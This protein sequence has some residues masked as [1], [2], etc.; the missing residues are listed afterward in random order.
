VYT[1]EAG[2]LASVTVIVLVVASTVP[3][4]EFIRRETEN[5]SA[6]E[7]PSATSVLIKLA[8]PLVNVM[9][10][11]SSPSEKSLVLIMPDTLFTV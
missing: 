8:L 10:P 5:A 4:T 1:V 7:A 2:G 6:S 9:V 11:D 3:P